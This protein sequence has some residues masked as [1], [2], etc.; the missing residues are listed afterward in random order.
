MPAHLDEPKNHKK[1]KAFLEAGGTH[2]MIEGN[3][4]A[5]ELAKEGAE[6]HAYTKH[7]TNYISTESNS[8]RL[9]KTC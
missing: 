7:T 4:G 2:Q 6:M 5:D 9:S 1:L 3:C 8:H